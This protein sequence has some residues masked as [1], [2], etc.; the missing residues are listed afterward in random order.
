MHGMA[1]YQITPVDELRH[2]AEDEGKSAE[3][4]AEITEPKRELHF[5]A[6]GVK[7]I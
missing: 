4:V 7:L 6:D 1:Y 5:L 3:E 2:Y